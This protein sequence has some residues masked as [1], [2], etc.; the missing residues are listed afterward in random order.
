[1]C[2]IPIAIDDQERIARAILNIHLNEKGKLKTNT[3]RPK[4]GKPD[5]SV[6]RHSYMG[7]DACK[8]KAKGIRS[9]SPNI[10]YK[11]LAVIGA[12]QIRN[13]GSE[14]TDSREGKDHYCGHADI[15]HG[16]PPPPGEPDDP[17]LVEKLRALKN[18][19]R[20]YPDPDPSIEHWTG[21]QIL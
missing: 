20:Y 19:A 11:G 6:M 5:V 10:E 12:K 3:F 2:D 1:M 18:A 13:S 16:S 17:M 8:A 15:S 14:V 9:S 21:A 7:S 4:P